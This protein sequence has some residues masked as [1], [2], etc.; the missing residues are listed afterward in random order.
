MSLENAN[1]VKIHRRAILGSATLILLSAA[2]AGAQTPPSITIDKVQVVSNVLGTQIYSPQTIAIDPNS[3]FIL[4]SGTFQGQIPNT[5]LNVPSTQASMFMSLRDPFSL[6]SPS[7][8]Q[9][10]PPSA[11]GFVSHRITETHIVR[12]TAGNKHIFYGGDTVSNI[13]NIDLFSSVLP[14]SN[15]NTAVTVPFI[16]IAPGGQSSSIQ[17]FFI[18]KTS[19]SG[20]FQWVIQSDSSNLNNWQSPAVTLSDMS[21]DANEDVYLTGNVAPFIPA[22]AGAVIRLG[23]GGPIISAPAGGNFWVA[24]INAQGQA[25]WAYIGGQGNAQRIKI[26]PSGALFV[27]GSMANAAIP[28]GFPSFLSPPLTSFG[29]NDVF[30]L[31]MDTSGQG[32]W[33]YLIG[34][35]ENDEVN[36]LAN[37][38]N[39]NFYL[40]MRAG[41]TTAPAAVT[42]D[43]NFHIPYPAQTSLIWSGLPFYNQELIIKLNYITNFNG[44]TGF[45][46]PSGTSNNA[47]V[48]SMDI[49]RCGD[50]IAAVNFS[51]PTLSLFDLGQI[52]NSNPAPGIFTGYDTAIAKLSSNLTGISSL[53][54]GIPTSNELISEV[55]A[56]PALD[57]FAL[58]G[59]SSSSAFASVS[60]TASLI[61]NDPVNNSCP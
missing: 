21:V 42:T 57:Q 30:V 13:V 16:P 59:S 41:G 23:T 46:S 6:S 34:G 28:T 54:M 56:N 51:L 25:D 35:A 53:Q 38:Q 2:L 8:L 43:V 3:S 17:E 24:K 60:V 5:V 18:A 14:S 48:A 49:T 15:P 33:A 20:G 11:P 7:G 32:Y 26:D 19:Q 44:V 9:F 52:A 37:D 55:K 31:F 40:S 58:I 61:D 4:E 39:G 1:A 29:L 10:A 36:D 47:R 12:D 27:A 22:N 50:V 45:E